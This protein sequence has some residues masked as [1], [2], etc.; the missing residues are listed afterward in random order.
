MLS[1]LNWRFVSLKDDEVIGGENTTDHQVNPP[2]DSEDRG[3]NQQRWH[4]EWKLGR[5]MYAL[6]TRFFCTFGARLACSVGA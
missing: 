5:N 4:A 3:P 6:R 1:P 2:L